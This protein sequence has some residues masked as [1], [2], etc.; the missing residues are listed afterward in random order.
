MRGEEFLFDA[1]F[2][3]YEYYLELQGV[4]QEDFDSM[5]FD[6]EGNEISE[7]D[8]L[9]EK[10]EEVLCEDVID[11]VYCSIIED[12]LPKEV[13]KDYFIN[14]LFSKYY[15]YNYKPNDP[16]IKYFNNTDAQDIYTLFIENYDFGIA[17][18]KSYFCTL[19]EP[20]ICDENRKSIYENQDEEH[21]L[22]F[23][24][25]LSY[26]NIVILNDLLRNVICNLY[27][28]FISNG[29]DDITALNN[30]WAYFTS[31]FD[32]L[33]E[34]DNM[35]IDFNSKK[36]YK[37]YMLGLV[38]ADVYEDACNKSIIDS[39]N[40]EDTLADVTSILGVSFSQIVIPR[41]E[42][43]RNRI[44][45]HF[46]LLQDEREKRKANRKKT[47]EDGRVETLKKVNPA[48]KLDELTF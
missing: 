29:C 44:L 9:K 4:S 24:K 17:V 39:E 2:D 47:Y 23:E 5:F 38:F 14:L 12:G 36:A 34:L 1:L 20:E 30:T 3:M 35:G 7:E 8:Y 46:I 32:P 40:F 21:L 26:T 25:K 6:E 15:L 10:A 19:V 16:V 18:I 42:G 11:S 41:E 37:R 27:N 45:K 31:N 28:H 48:Y 22:R 43:V 13:D 33:G